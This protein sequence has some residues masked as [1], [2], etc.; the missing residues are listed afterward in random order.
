MCNRYEK[1]LK[2]S[3][4]K[5]MDIAD[6]SKIFRMELKASDTKMVNTI[7]LL[8]NLSGTKFDLNKWKR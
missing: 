1:C 3:P 8:N 5:R 7:I 4:I 6:L 2:N